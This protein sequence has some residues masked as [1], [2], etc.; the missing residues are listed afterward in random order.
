MHIAWAKLRCFVYLLCWGMWRG[1]REVRMYD[2]G[3]RLLTLYTIRGTLSG[4]QD[5][6]KVF[7]LR[8]HN[9]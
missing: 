2:H 3:G 9:E 1:E 4:K 6:R 5:I 8:K 7:Y